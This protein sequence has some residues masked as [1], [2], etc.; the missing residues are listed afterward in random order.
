MHIHE[1][2]TISG[3]LQCGASITGETTS[4]ENHYYEFDNKDAG[5]VIGISLC[6]SSYDTYLYLRDAGFN[7]IATNDDSCGYQS[8]IVAELSSTD[9]YYI[10]VSGYGGAYGP[11]TMDINCS[12]TPIEY[13]VID[14]L[15]SSLPIEAFSWSDVE[16]YTECQDPRFSAWCSLAAFNTSSYFQADLGELYIIYSIST[17]GIDDYCCGPEW[18]ESYDLEYSIDGISFISYINNPLPGNVDYFT[19]QNNALQPT[20]VAQFL[21]FIPVSFQNWKSM[22]VDASGSSLVSPYACIYLVHD[23]S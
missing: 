4:S 12:I 3:Y 1:G 7:L 14:N 10:E 23:Q 2:V 13:A 6:G 18:V 9:I 20:I 21:R 16:S 15:L 22:R 5:N 17:W 19:E 11:Y 8:E